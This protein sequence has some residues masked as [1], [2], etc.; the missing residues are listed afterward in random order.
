M[1]TLLFSVINL[2]EELLPCDICGRTFLPGSLK[3]HTSVCERNAKKKRTVFDSQKQRVEG[4]EIAS[5]QQPSQTKKQTQVSE[6]P[7]K[8]NKWKERHLELVNTIRTARNINATVEMSNSGSTATFHNPTLATGSSDRCLF[9]DRQFGPRA[10]DRH[11]EWCKERTARVKKSPADVMLAKERLAA[12]TKYKVPLPIKSKR[13][14][15]KEKYSPTLENRTDSFSSTKSRSCVNLDRVTT[16]NKFKSV[17]Q[18]SDISVH[19]GANATD[20]PTYQKLDTRRNHGDRSLK[21]KKSL[22][23]DKSA[24]DLKS[25]IQ[26][27]Y[28]PFLTAER[29]LMELLECDDFKPFFNKQSSTKPTHRPHT[30]NIVKTNQN[31]FLES[32]TLKSAENSR[33]N[34]DVA[35]RTSVLEPPSD[36]QDGDDFEIIESL[37]NQNFLEG[38]E[39][40][41]LNNTSNKIFSES[42]TNLLYPFDDCGNNSLNKNSQYNDDI[43]TIDPRLINEYDNLAIPKTLNVDSC[44]SS[45]SNDH[46][47]RLVNVMDGLKINAV[48]L[49]KVSSN[50]K[51]II[52]NTRLNIK[53]LPKQSKSKSS[54]SLNSS[55][56]SNNI[57]S[58]KKKS[59]NTV[60]R[61]VSI[62]EAPN[63]S[64]LKTKKDVDHYINQQEKNNTLKP[65]QPKH[66]EG[67][68]EINSPKTDDLFSINDEMY[69]EYKIYE[70]LYLKEKHLHD[71]K[72]EITVNNVTDCE[73]AEFVGRCNFSKSCTD[74]AYSRSNPKIRSKLNKL[75]PL[76]YQ[77]PNLSPDGSS[78]SSSSEIAKNTKKN[79]MS[80]FCHECGCKYPIDTNRICASILRRSLHIVRRNSFDVRCGETKTYITVDHKYDVVIMGA[81][82][83]GLRT[84]FGLSAACY[85]SAVITK[86]FPTRS[87]TVA[88]QGG[89]NA[90]LGNMEQDKWEWHMYDTVKGS[91]WLGDQ[92]AIHYMTKEAPTA[93]KELENYGM[94]F[95]R[96]RDGKIYQRAFGGQ[97]LDFGK[98]SQAHRTCAV[99]DRTGH[100][101]LHTLYGE[102]LKYDCHYY[103][104]YFVLGVMIECGECIGLIAWCLEDGTLHRFFAQNTVIASGGYGRVY[105]S[106]TSA[107]TCTGDGIGILSR[108]GLPMQDMEFIQFH[109]TGIYGSGCLMTE[110]CRGE[111]GF[112]INGV[113]ERFMEKYAP[114]AK[115][116]ASRDV[117]SRAMT[118]EI[119]EGRGVGKEKDHIFL[120]LH[121][122]PKETIQTRLPGISETAM[123]FAGV[124]VTRQPVPV[125]PTVHYNMGG[126]PTNW[127]GEVVLHKVNDKY[128]PL[129]GLYACGE[130]ACASVHGANRLG[131]N[132]L[133]EIV[134]F[135]RSVVESIK[136]RSKVGEKVTLA[137]DNSGEE[138][139]ANFDMLRYTDGCKNTGCIRTEMQKIMQNNCAVFR[140]EDT[141]N[142]AVTL[143]YDVYS[144]FKTCKV[145][146]RGL[147]WNSDLVE[148]LELQNLML[149]ALQIAA[150]AANRKESRGAHARE[151][152]KQRIDEYDYS[153]P[154]EGQQKKSLEQHWRKHSLSTVALD[155]GCVQLDYR[156]VIDCTLDDKTP[157]VPPMIRQY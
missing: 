118:V 87:H 142:E 146:D 128:C 149:C 126:I 9:C 39:F 65:N 120:Q 15:V 44:S 138:A 137:R 141:L 28:S 82:G 113:G 152:Y 29:Q 40:H 111:G 21:E 56:L 38:N 135:A 76:E 32:K 101:L 98:G 27:D 119:R 23:E 12:R 6:T 117:V 57:G 1:L 31:K 153:K 75:N 93:I 112:L 16:T 74:S 63:K 4:T 8:V 47:K 55:F 108:L 36:F 84:A 155:T 95:S 156:P 25:G 83:A 151:D 17:R 89:V 114:S 24:L 92:D 103:I 150:C 127:K 154:L 77:N 52:R 60:K 62:R 71:P 69:E 67:S 147:I 37:I 73:D 30:V 51:P 125:I 64:N 45:S 133:L 122:I 22:P 46:G 7:K 59:L 35:K 33:K 13:T 109:P 19:D 129:P 157:S 124:D 145:S 10:F 50:I 94:P 26:H 106:C 110:G 5:F 136:S 139:I 42:L 148:C 41:T 11:V 96:T 100:S 90:A 68:E 131:A 49:E 61:S 91:D 102:S 70:Q 132:S 88:A 2:E 48:N 54:L 20:L 66:P 3:K 80:K 140:D 115:E 85:K 99:A 130:V 116:L 143:M 72:T 123:I 81:G 79:R 78:S 121:H 86:L 58:D 134:C 14:V 105:F 53:K 97:S 144:E 107:H 34:L 104:E 18:V 43:T